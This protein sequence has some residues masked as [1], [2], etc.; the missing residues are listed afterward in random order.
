MWAKLAAVIRRLFRRKEAPAVPVDREAE[1]DE[2]IDCLYAA[3][4]AERS[5]ALGRV[6]AQREL[7]ATLASSFRMAAKLERSGDRELAELIR[8]T[9]HGLFRHS[10]VFDPTP[11]AALAMPVPLSY[12]RIAVHGPFIDSQTA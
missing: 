8:L 7:V 12:Q 1:V 2:I 10:D 9:V 3:S 5:A 11:S 4:S 6:Q